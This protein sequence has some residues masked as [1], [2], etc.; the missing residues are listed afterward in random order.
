MYSLVLMTALA[1]APEMPN[2]GWKCGCHG[3]GYGH[4]CYGSGCYGGGYYGGGCYG[5]YG[6][7]GGYGCYGAGCWGVPVAPAMQ[8]KPAEPVPPPKVDGKPGSAAAALQGKL[9]V[10]LP[11]DARLFVDEQRIQAPAGRRTFNTPVLT[12]GQSYY[13]MVRVEIDINGKTQEE[14]KQV[15]VRA[16]QTSEV[17]FPQLIALRKQSKPAVIS[18]Q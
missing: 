8:M 10:E 3:G 5:C 2:C 18:A 4:G 17:A 11:D 1:T 14:T 13:Y 7:M 6:C 12:P 16:G 15:I 9:L